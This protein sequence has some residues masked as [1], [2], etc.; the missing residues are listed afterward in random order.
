MDFGRYYNGKNYR[1]ID[2]N[3][4]IDVRWGVIE[5]VKYCLI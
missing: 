4:Y 3:S 2:R 1:E 5:L